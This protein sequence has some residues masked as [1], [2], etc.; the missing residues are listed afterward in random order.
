MTKLK[1]KKFELIT[2][3]SKENILNYTYFKP[4]TRILNALSMTFCVG[5]RFFCESIR[6]HSEFQ[7]D[8]VVLEIK[9]FIKQESQHSMAHKSLNNILQTSYGVNLI[10]CENS[11]IKKLNEL[12]ITPQKKLLTTVCLEEL[13]AFGGWLYLL[14][15]KVFFKN[16]LQTTKLWHEHAKEEVDHRFVARTVYEKVYGKNKLKFLLHFA[17]TS[18]KLFSQVVEN[19]QILKQSEKEN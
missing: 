12:G 18:A 11:A 13:T 7:D 10:S 19:Y 16:N 2:D 3:T 15:G 5:E 6:F 9:E 17:K 14:G 8:D 4:L 1:S